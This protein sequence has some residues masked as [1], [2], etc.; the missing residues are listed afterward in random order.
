VVKLLRGECSARRAQALDLIQSNDA[1][2]LR[3]KV[4]ESGSLEA[5]RRVASELVARAKGQLA[6]VPPGPVR[7]LLHTMADAVVDRSF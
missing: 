2:G 7:D 3:A 1:V 5:A 4:V 6:C